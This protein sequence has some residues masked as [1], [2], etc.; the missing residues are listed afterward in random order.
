MYKRGFRDISD[1]ERPLA[2]AADALVRVYDLT[3]VYY[4]TFHFKKEQLNR[5]LEVE[6]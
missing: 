6:K 5:R 1:R 3:R 4:C 2:L